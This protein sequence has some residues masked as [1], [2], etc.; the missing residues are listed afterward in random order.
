MRLHK[1]LCPV[2]TIPKSVISIF[3]ASQMK[4]LSGS[5]PKGEPKVIDQNERLN[6]CS[7]HS[8]RK[9]IKL[10]DSTHRSLEEEYYSKV[11]F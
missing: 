7:E 9:R 1:L 8:T 5:Q 11:R 4:C 10:E 3:E 6:L 2:R